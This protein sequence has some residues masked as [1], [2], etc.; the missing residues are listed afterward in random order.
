MKTAKLI[1]ISAII[2]SCSGNNQKTKETIMESDSILKKEEK[3][4]LIITEPKSNNT[5]IPSYWSSLSAIQK[6][7]IEVEK[8]KDGYLIYEPC[9]GTTPTIKLDR[10]KLIIRPQIEFEKEYEYDKFTRIT[11]NKSFRMDTKIGEIKAII[12]DS[13]KGLVLWEISG[14]KKLMTPIEKSENFRHIKN[15]R[16]DRKRKEL[17]FDTID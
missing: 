8:D 17:R 13:K 16:P 7:W 14:E 2:C 1:V 11:G 12:F 3:L 10:G 5:E 9:D 15:N 4:D 6:E